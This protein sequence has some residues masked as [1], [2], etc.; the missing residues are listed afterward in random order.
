MLVWRLHNHTAPYAKQNIYDPLDGT[1]AAFSPGRWNL[2]GVPLLYTSSTASLA[3]LEVLMHVAPRDFGIRELIEIEVPD[4]TI[5]DATAMVISSAFG[6]GDEPTQVYGS[7]WAKEKRSLCLSV[8][9]AP[10]PLE[11]NILL[12]PMHPQMR[13]VRVRRR[14]PYILDPRIRELKK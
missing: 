6:K 11:H 8:P 14:I 3:V 7:N 5:E 10:M 4:E 12:N 9:S 1:G 13:K 2:Q